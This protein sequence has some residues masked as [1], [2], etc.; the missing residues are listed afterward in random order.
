MALKKS[1][2]ELEKVV[3]E[4]DNEEV[5]T[6]GQTATDEDGV[7]RDEPLLAGIE[8]EGQFLKTFS[9]REMNGK[10]EEAINKAEVRNNGAKLVNTLLERTVVDIGGITKKDIGARKWGELIRSLIGADLDYMS[11]KVREISKGTEITF[12]HKCPQCKT[13]LKTIMDT[14]EFEIIPFNGLFEIPFELPRG[15][16]DTKGVIHKNGILRQA[17]GLDREIIV[18]LYK[19]NVASAKTM[20]L[21]RLMTFDDGTQVFND[22]VADMTLRDREYLEKLIEENIFGINTAIEVVCDNCGEELTGQLGNSDF[23]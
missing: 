12:T 11:L 3:D 9:Y 19:K 5:R 1:K 15:Y 21:T 17:N 13:T 10:D 22:K 4:I 7:V 8:W 18:P 14:S 2:D 20:L 16:K 23:F 6:L